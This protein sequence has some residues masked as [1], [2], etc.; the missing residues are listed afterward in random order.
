[1]RQS[2]KALQQLGVDVTC[3]EAAEAAGWPFWD[4]AARKFIHDVVEA[5]G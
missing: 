4:T 1:M 2:A 3:Y 5:S